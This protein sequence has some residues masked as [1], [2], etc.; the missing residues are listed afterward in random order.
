MPDYEIQIGVYV[1]AKTKADAEKLAD[2]IQSELTEQLAA[3]R[4][5]DQHGSM[6]WWDVNEI[7][8]AK[9]WPDA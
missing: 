2:K 9:P 3:V 6:G 5:R 8:D 4:R 1:Q 7:I